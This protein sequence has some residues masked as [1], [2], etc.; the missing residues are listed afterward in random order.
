MNNLKIILIVG[1]VIV[2]GLCVFAICDANRILSHEEIAS[3]CEPVSVGYYYRDNSFYLPVS[4][5]GDTVEMIMDNHCQSMMKDDRLKEIGRPIGS[6]VLKGKDLEGHRHN[7]KYYLIDSVEL[8]NNYSNVIFKSISSGDFLWEATDDGILGSNFICSFSWHFA[9]SSHIVEVSSDSLPG[10]LQGYQKIEDGLSPNGINVSFCDNVQGKFTLDM[11]CEDEMLINKKLFS[12]LS[13]VKQYDTYHYLTPQNTVTT[14]FVFTDVS[15]RIDG[16]AYTSHRVL[17]E[18]GINRNILGAPLLRNRDFILDFPTGR[19][20][21]GDYGVQENKDDGSGL[22]N[23]YGVSYGNRN[24]K[25]VVVLI[26]E[27]SK[28]DTDGVKLGDAKGSGLL[29]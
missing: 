19:L 14:A 4:I 22:V 12:K 17:F 5:K 3:F 16:K 7:N 13:A 26:K 29:K 25:E 8:G 20:F 9:D 15:F 21:I 11:G 10:I 2:A 24:G 18:E 27:G 1:I 23:E 6:I 28:A